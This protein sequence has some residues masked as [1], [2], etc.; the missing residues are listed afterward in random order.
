[1]SEEIQ[2]VRLTLWDW[3][4]SIVASVL[5]QTVCYVAVTYATQGITRLHRLPVMASGSKLA[6][7]FYLAKL[8]LLLA[9]VDGHARNVMEVTQVVLLIPMGCLERNV[10][11]M[12]AGR[13]AVLRQNKNK[14]WV[15]QQSVTVSPH[16]RARNATN[17]NNT[18]T[19]FMAAADRTYR[20]L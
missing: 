5:R 3:L 20:V 11:L 4:P 14:I 18:K 1:M 17:A 10:D 15:I 13:D 16:Q 2:S 7:I 8:K 19:V 12:R 6:A 9:S